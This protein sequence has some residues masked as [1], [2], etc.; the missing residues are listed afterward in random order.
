MAYEIFTRKV[1]RM[2]SPAIAI[3]RYGR[4]NINKAFTELLRHKAIERVLLMWDAESRKIGIR[5]IS[6]KDSRAYELSFDQK[7]RGS[8]VS[9]KTFLDWIGYDYSQTR[10]FNVEWNDKEDIFEIALPP[11][12]FTDANKPA[13]EQRS[14]RSVGRKAS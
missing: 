14:I 11:D 6:K 8:N 12:V 1:T 2:G 5:Q 13:A 3:G 9:A 10:S 7:N 4:L